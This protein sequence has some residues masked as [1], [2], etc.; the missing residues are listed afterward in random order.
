[1]DA[2]PSL[3]RDDILACHFTLSAFY[4][5]RRA[6]LMEGNAAARPQM[7]YQAKGFVCAVHRVAQ[8]MQS[9][10]GA[11]VFPDP[12]SDTIRLAWK[13]KREMLESYRDARDAIEHIDTKI[14]GRT[15]WFLMNLLNDRLMV[16]ETD[17][18]EVSEPVLRRIVDMW[19]EVIA[20]V[21]AHIT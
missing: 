16:T 12:V 5:A 3:V 8:L 21:K 6:F 1:M 9:R 20:G 10:P 11:R 2:L 13:K 4:S 7:F 18:A 15:S 19:E 17:G 14:R